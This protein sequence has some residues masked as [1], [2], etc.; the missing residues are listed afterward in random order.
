VARNPW[1]SRTRMMGVVAGGVLA[2]VVV[3][4][5]LVELLIKR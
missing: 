1:R 4:W 5:L 2:G 3:G